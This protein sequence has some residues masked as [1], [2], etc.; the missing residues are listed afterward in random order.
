MNPTV[1]VVAQGAMGAGVGGRLV[2]RGL[3]GHH[4]AATGAAKRAPSAPRRPAWSRPPTR[5]ARRRILPVDLPA[6]RC[7]W[8]WPRRWRS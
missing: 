4:L 1:A 6:E 2:E 5:N 8:R 7:A 3:T